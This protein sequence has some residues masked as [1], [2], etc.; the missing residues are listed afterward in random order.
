M[1]YKDAYDLEVEW[2]EKWTGLHGDAHHPETRYS[3]SQCAEMIEI[4]GP[5]PPRH[6]LQMYVDAA[7]NESNRPPISP[8]LRWEIWERDDFRCVGCGSR[9]HLSI[10][11]IIP[12]S[13]GGGHDGDNLQTMC[14]T[15]NSRKGVRMP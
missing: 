15:C 13:K 6:L 11:H 2:V 10:D 1:T 14:R 9:R 4:Y 7:P 12:K 8:D 3:C 5:M